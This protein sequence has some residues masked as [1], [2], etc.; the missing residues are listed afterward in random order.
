M[1]TEEKFLTV[2]EAIEY[3]KQGGV[4]TDDQVRVRLYRARALSILYLEKDLESGTV[5]EKERIT[6]FN[7]LQN[8]VVKWEES[9]AAQN[10]L[11]ENKI[12]RIEITLKASDDK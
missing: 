8:S 2:D 10:P 9:H 11:D 7:S 1:E 6:A 12:R 4:L 5:V 3:V